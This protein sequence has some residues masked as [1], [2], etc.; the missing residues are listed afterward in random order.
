MLICLTFRLTTIQKIW[1]KFRSCFISIFKLL[2]FT[3]RHYLPSRVWA[4][5]FPDLIATIKGIVK[6]VLA[7]ELEVWIFENLFFS[8]PFIFDNLPSFLQKIHLHCHLVCFYKNRTCVW[9]TVTNSNRFEKKQHRV[10]RLFIPF[11]LYFLKSQLRFWKTRIMSHNWNSS[12][13][14]YGAF[15]SRSREEANDRSRAQ[16]GSSES[17]QEACER[18]GRISGT[19]GVPLR[20]KSRLKTWISQWISFENE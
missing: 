1:R 4:A 11:L 5:R 9:L 20:F 15:N 19:I 10:S 7:R 18:N 13:C 17:A 14:D 8:W 16:K 2:G 6:T 3:R 12:F